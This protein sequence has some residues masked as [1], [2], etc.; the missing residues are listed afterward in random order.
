MRP[1]GVPL[2]HSCSLLLTAKNNAV[3]IFQIDLWGRKRA[4]VAVQDL[5]VPDYLYQLKQLQI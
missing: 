5:G 2:L 4:L 3:V 1:L